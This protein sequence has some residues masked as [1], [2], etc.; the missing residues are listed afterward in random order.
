MII[1]SIVSTAQ[2]PQVTAKETP[3]LK[4]KIWRWHSFLI[5]QISKESCLESD[6]SRLFSFKGSVREK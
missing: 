4:E 3:E 5:Q 1:F 2:N 6:V